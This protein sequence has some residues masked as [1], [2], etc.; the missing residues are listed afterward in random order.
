MNMILNQRIFAGMEISN[1]R[2]AYPLDQIAMARSRNPNAV[3]PGADRLQATVA[4]TSVMAA[5]RS[6]RS[7]Y[8][9]MEISMIELIFLIAAHDGSVLR[10]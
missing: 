7:A 6:E 1:Q 2:V 8:G 9:W 10:L 4:A 5:E 3:E